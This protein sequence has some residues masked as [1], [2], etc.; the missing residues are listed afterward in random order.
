MTD[1]EKAL[2]QA[3]LEYVTRYG[4]TQKAKTILNRSPE[5]DVRIGAQKINAISVNDR[6]DS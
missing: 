4:M 2:E 1:L 6:S 3:L 5:S